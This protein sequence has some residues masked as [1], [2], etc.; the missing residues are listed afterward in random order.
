M[1]RSDD[2]TVI[3]GTCGGLQ[4]RWIAVQLLQKLPT[5][6]TRR[7]NQGMKT[8]TISIKISP[9]PL[10]GQSLARPDCESRYRDAM[11]EKT[12]CR[13]LKRGENSG[14]ARDVHVACWC[15]KKGERWWRKCSGGMALCAHDL[16]SWPLKK[17][18]GDGNY[19]A[20]S[21]TEREKAEEVV[22]RRLNVWV[23]LVVTQ[24]L[25]DR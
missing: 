5:A 23:E 12:N 10:H 1:G 16:R 25:Q 8:I 4:K 11:V 14:V 6:T 17:G 3:N 20:A 22:R 18:E 15:W 2:R 9:C 24:L 19:N 21:T 13:L 7:C